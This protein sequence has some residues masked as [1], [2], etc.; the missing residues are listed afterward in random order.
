MIQNAVQF[1]YKA[2]NFFAGLGLEFATVSVST[3]TEY[4]YGEQT[5]TF[6][7]KVS[8]NLFMPQIGTRYFFAKGAN[9]GGYVTPY[10]GANLFYTLGKV[11]ISQS[12]GQTTYRDTTTEKILNDVLSG[13]IGGTLGFGGEYYFSKNFSIGGEF[14]IRMLFGSTKTEVPDYYY[15]HTM[16]NNLGL[17]VTYTTLGLNFYF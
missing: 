3:K 14:G 4:K 7:T 1:G 12:D 5:Q 10:I 2:D 11:S 13:N 16:S 17:G 15:E 8:G 6:T 9:E